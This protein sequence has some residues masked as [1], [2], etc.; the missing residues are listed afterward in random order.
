MPSQF[1][2]IG[3]YKMSNDIINQNADEQ[4]P[5]NTQDAATT[6]APVEASEQ[7]SQTEASETA[8]AEKPVAEKKEPFAPHLKHLT[9]ILTGVLTKEM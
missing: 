1:K 6:N 2:T 8:V 3:I 7:T 5:A 4:D 9:M